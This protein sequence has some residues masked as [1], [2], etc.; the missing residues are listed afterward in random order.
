LDSKLINYDTLS[1]VGSYKL[2]LKI[3]PFPSSDIVWVTVCYGLW[4][5]IVVISEDILAQS[6]T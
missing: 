1:L 6:K 5:F 3:I 2:D 4:I